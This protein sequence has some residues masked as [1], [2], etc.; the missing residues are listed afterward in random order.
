MTSCN[1][2]RCVREKNQMIVNEFV[3]FVE[4]IVPWLHDL[5][6]PELKPKPH[7]STENSPFNISH[8]SPKKQ[9][10]FPAGKLHMG[11]A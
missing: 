10:L 5:T 4:H 7:N 8:A 1:F 9:S 11:H 6:I 2:L 3:T